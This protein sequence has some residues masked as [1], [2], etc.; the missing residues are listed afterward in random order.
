M[1]RKSLNHILNDLSQCPRPVPPSG[2]LVSGIGAP[3]SWIPR[4][5]SGSLLQGPSASHPHPVSLQ[6]PSLASPS[7]GVSGPPQSPPSFSHTT[8]PFS[9][10]PGPPAQLLLGALERVLRARSVI[11]FSLTWFLGSGIKFQ[12]GIFRNSL[13]FFGGI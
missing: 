10:Q 13:L 8:A 1:A 6:A 9:T 5:K 7:D 11:E 12:K 3:P 2:C 4:Q